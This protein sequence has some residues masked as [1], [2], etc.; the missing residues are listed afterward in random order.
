MVY[1]LRV[2]ENKRYG[3][4]CGMSYILGKEREKIGIYVFICIKKRRNK[5]LV[6]TISSFIIMGSRR[7]EDFLWIFLIIVNLIL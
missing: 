5:N 4:G 3:I 1:R 7:E 6:I 2:G